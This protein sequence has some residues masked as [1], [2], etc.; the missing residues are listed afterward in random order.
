MKNIRLILTAALM[1]STINFV[2]AHD[3]NLPVNTKWKECSFQLDPSLT[4]DAWHQFAQEAGLVIYFRPLIVAKPLGTGRFELSVLQWN[5]KI[6]E[7]QDAWNN[8]FVHPNSEHWLIGGEELPFPGLSL[9]AGITNKLDAGIYW[10]ERPGAN[11]G[12]VGAQVQYNFINDTTKNW[13]VSTRANVSSLYGPADLN[14]Y[15]CG[16]DL[17]ASKKLAVITDKVSVSPYAGISSFGSIAHEKTDAVDLKDEY[18]SGLQSMAG[19]SAQI[20]FARLGVEYNFAKVNT[21]SYKLGVNFK[22]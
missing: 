22:F 18:V 20:Y 21:F 16:V 7:S 5:T 13:A 11:Y 15:V 17:L 8:T 3:P 4:Q 10:S 12:V 2:S 19:A 9:R 14:L 1:Y 6:D